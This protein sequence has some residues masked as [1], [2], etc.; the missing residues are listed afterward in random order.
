M[1]NFAE[2]HSLRTFKE[3]K[4]AKGNAVAMEKWLRADK[5]VD[6]VYV[7]LC[8]GLTKSDV[9][10]KMAEG[11][12]EHQNGK[13][14]KERTAVDYLRAAMQRMAYDYEKD[15]EQLRAD[16]YTKLTAV[17]ADAVEHNDRYNAINA[18]QTLMKLTGVAMDKPHTQVNLNTNGDIKISFGFGNDKE[19]DVDDVD[20]SEE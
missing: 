11:L 20:Y 19:N 17:Y 14:I 16:L 13:A 3:R 6:E 7:D 4:A 1:S 5:I 2:S 12:Y 8:N 9:V 15:A 10:Q 18:L